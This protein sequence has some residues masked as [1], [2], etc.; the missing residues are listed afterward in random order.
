MTAAAVRDVDGTVLDTGRTR[1][2]QR[3]DC[4]GVAVDSFLVTRVANELATF[5]TDATSGL[6][7]LM[8]V[9]ETVVE[10]PALVAD[11]TRLLFVAGGGNTLDA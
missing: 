2:E 11:P 5:D 4:V 8:I 9:D 10:T 1:V 3:C 7:L 6:R